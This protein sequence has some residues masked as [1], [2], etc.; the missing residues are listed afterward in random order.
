MTEV[1][2][3]FILMRDA[4]KPE[5]LRIMVRGKDMEFNLYTSEDELAS[6]R[7]VLGDSK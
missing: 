5:Q 4:G 1:K 7:E 6:L 2:L 3:S